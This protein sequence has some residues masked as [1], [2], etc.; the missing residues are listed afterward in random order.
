M[1]SPHHCLIVVLFTVFVSV[2]A[3]YFPIAVGNSWEYLISLDDM[4]ASEPRALDKKQVT[5]TELLEIVDR[6]IYDN[7][8]VFHVKVTFKM[9]DV[10]ESYTGCF[11]SS[12]NDILYFDT[13]GEEKPYEKGFEHQPVA[14]HEWDMS[15][16]NRKI[17][18]YGPITVAAGTFSSCYAI[19]ENGDTSEVYAPDIG[20]VA[21]L[22]N[23]KLIMQL[24]AY[25][26]AP[27]SQV[28]FLNKPEMNRQPASYADRNAGY[29]SVVNVLGRRVDWGT[30]QNGNNVRHATSPGIYFQRDANP[31]YGERSVQKRCVIGR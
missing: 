24:T 19:Q 7:D 17:V 28:R 15:G 29:L 27:S 8:T 9:E 25:T 18:Y 21:A 22:S 30:A 12:G 26:V 2:A 4:E 1:K 20:M 16:V 3:D 23:G 10:T 13:L 11:M 31:T 5:G 6:T 14:G